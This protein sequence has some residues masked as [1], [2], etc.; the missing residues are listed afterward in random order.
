MSLGLGDLNKKRRVRVAKTPAQS[1]YPV[2]AWAKS[3]T[4]RP[5]TASGETRP[6]RSRKSPVDTDA[7]MNEDWVSVYSAPL[8]WMDLSEHSLLLRLH[9]RLLETEN[10]VQT[11]LRG[12]VEKVRQFMGLDESD[13][14][15]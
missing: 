1:K 11:L 14:Q 12:P 7:H 15:K 13:D 5:W 10:R 9:N 8:C 6:G 3:H 2:G 4:A